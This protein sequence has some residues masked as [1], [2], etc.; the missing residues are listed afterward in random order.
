MPQ[1][2]ALSTP[3]SQ[4]DWTSSDDRVRGGSSYSKILPSPNKHTAKFEGNLDITTLDGA[5][6]ASQHI[7]G[8]H[9]RWDLSAADGLELDLGISESDG[10]L[11]TLILKDEI[12]PAR[13]DGRERSS[14]SWEADFRASAGCKTTEQKNKKKVIIK[15]EGLRPTYRGK[16]VKG[17]HALD[18]KSVRRLSIMMRSFFG[19]QEGP[20]TLSIVSIATWLGDEESGKDGG[21]VIGTRE[22]DTCVYEDNSLCDIIT[23]YSTSPLFQQCQHSSSRQ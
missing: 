1:T 14:L 17:A 9:T 19:A 7:T 3:W 15:W 12:L 13:P 22:K 21:V 11:Y 2:E 6:F 4:N 20:F 10:K 18:L 23:Y 8:D 16:E 5:G